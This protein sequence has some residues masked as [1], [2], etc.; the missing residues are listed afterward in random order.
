MKQTRPPE[1]RDELTDQ[2]EALIRS[3]E[4]N[5]VDVAGGY[6]FRTESEKPDWSLELLRLAKP[7]R[8]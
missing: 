2:L 5:G 8:S 6:S 7:A 4:A 3:A 1:T